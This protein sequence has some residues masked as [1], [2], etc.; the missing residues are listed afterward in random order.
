M[1]RPT[2]TRI[3]LTYSD[4]SMQFAFDARAEAMVRFFERLQAAARELGI[5]VDDCPQFETLAPAVTE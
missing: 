1:S 5:P 3:E 4:G 2:C